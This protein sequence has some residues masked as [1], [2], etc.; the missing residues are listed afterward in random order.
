MKVIYLDNHA[1]TPLDPRVL[2]SMTPYFLEKFGNPSSRT[3]QYGWEAEEAID[4]AREQVANLINAEPEEIFFTSGATESNN[5]VL[6]NFDKIYI[7]AIEHSSIYNL[8]KSKLGVWDVDEIKV[9]RDGVVDLKYLEWLLKTTPLLMSVMLVNNEVGTIQPIKKITSMTSALVHSDMAQAAGKIK[10]DVRELGVDFA[11]LSSHKM[12]GPKGAGALYIKKGVSLNPLMIGGHQ[13]FGLRPGTPNVPAIVGFGTAC[14]IIGNE[15]EEDNKRIKVMRAE[16]YNILTE[17]LAITEFNGAEN[18]VDCN[19]NIPIPCLDIDAFLGESAGVAF[20][21]GSACNGQTESR[22]L[23]AMGI[24]DEVIKRSLRFSFGKFNTNEEVKIA[25]NIICDAV[26][27]V[28][29]RTK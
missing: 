9:N 7:S 5:I 10:I 24:S 2:S 6:N 4:V 25:A 11:S 29:R 3:H 13:E 28:N 23:K 15:M 20:S 26:I 16:F 14:E 18:N 1:T 22:T 21:F 19:L 8:C 17:R 27:N 12:Y